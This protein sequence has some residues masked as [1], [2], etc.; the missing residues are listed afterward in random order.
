[1]QQSRLGRF[2]SP[3]E[4]L[5]TMSMSRANG[6]VASLRQR[7]IELLDTRIAPVDQRTC[8]RRFGEPQHPECGDVKSLGGSVSKKGSLY[9]C[10][11]SQPE[12]RERVRVLK[13]QNVRGLARPQVVQQGGNVF[14]TFPEFYNEALIT[15]ALSGHPDVFI[16]MDYGGRCRLW[17]GFGMTRMQ[18]QIIMDNASCVDLWL[19]TNSQLEQAD[20]WTRR[21]QYLMHMLREL[22][23]I[24]T[25]AHKQYKFIHADPKAGNIFVDC[26]PGGRFEESRLVFGDMGMSRIVVEN[27]L[28]GANVRQINLAR[29][30]VIRMGTSLAC[31]MRTQQVLSGFSNGIYRYPDVK[32]ST[33]L[34]VLRYARDIP[35]VPAIE[36]PLTLSSALLNPRH[37]GHWA[38]SMFVPVV[39]EAMFGEHASAYIDKLAY[40]RGRGNAKSVNTAYKAVAGL[41]LREDFLRRLARVPSEMDVRMRNQAIP[42]LAPVMPAP[43]PPMAQQTRLFRKRSDQARRQKLR[44]PRAYANSRTSSWRA[45]QREE[46]EKLLALRR[47]RRGT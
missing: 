34:S 13:L 11:P 17:G 24:Y 47:R 41:P 36:L 9:K 8:P 38:S 19:Y 12:R 6:S 10:I 46:R 21:E 30:C 27:V 29:E 31:T 39:A 22:L 23:R 32:P 40:L 20:T 15:A 5:E 44:A 42:H 14:I 35:K 18:G 7:L 26:P 3:R 25:F 43:P 33:F 37:A 4:T 1:M 28:Y 2:P 16:P 45:R